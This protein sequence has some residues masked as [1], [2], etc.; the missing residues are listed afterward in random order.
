MILPS[1]IAIPTSGS[2]ELRQFRRDDVP[3]QE[4]LLL[5]EL[6]RMLRTRR[7]LIVGCVLAGLLLAGFYIVVR[8]SRYEATARIEVSPVGT[9]ALGLDELSSRMLTTSDTT[10]QLQSAITVLESHTIALAV[11]QQVKMAEEERLRRTLGTTARRK[12]CRSHA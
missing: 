8:S 10:L 6:G 4:E 12:S 1:E 5:P 7:S 2:A 11:M 3:V 9:N